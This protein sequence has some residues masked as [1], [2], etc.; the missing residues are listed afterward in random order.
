MA[1]PPAERKAARSDVQTASARARSMKQ[2]V[3]GPMLVMDVEDILSVDL[4]GRVRTLPQPS[5]TQRW[6]I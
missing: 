6:G 1:F 4:I 3:S 2:N 5:R